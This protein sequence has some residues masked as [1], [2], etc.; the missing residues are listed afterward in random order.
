MA[1]VSSRP[2]LKSKQWSCSELQAGNAGLLRVKK[3]GDGQDA[4]QKKMKDWVGLNAPPM[5]TIDVCGAS[6]HNIYVLK[7]HVVCICLIFGGPL[8][9]MK[10]RLLL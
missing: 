7:K 9:S 1:G 5:S 2:T 4:I 3:E 8:R 10:P 6:M